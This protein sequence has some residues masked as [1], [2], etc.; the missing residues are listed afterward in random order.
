MNQHPETPNIEIEINRQLKQL[1]SADMVADAIL[2]T[3]EDKKL[4]A[5]DSESLAVYLLN[6]GLYLTLLSFFVR[7]AADGSQ[8]PWAQMGEALA[9]L[10]NDNEEL[11]KLLIEG[12]GAN[13]ALRQLSRCR[14]LD[15]VD[16]ELIEVRRKS[17]GYFLEIYEKRR[18]E[19]FNQLEL[20]KS[21]ELLEEEDKLLQIMDRHFP[22]DPSIR[23]AKIALQEKKALS[24][25]SGRPKQKA[26][27]P[28][29]NFHESL[30]E[31]EEKI[32]KVVQEQ[33][34]TILHQDP[35]LLSDF[36]YFNFFI[37]A[38]DHAV[39]L[40]AEFD[41][42]KSHPWLWAETLIRGRYF[43]EILDL[44]VSL[45]ET[46]LDDPE[47]VFAIHYLRAQALWGLNQKLQAIELMEGLVAIRPTY[48]AAQAILD[49]W[50]DEAQ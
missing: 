45:E 50:R 10:A 15:N 43:V 34:R 12:A 33:M 44:L 49:D 20:L 32:L 13:M 6:S 16:P 7:K 46:F 47:Q 19:F 23:D 29:R 1:E 48:R 21:Q 14:R 8:L 28:P 18:K 26:P 30:T 40:L 38:Y 4:S 36:V 9:M 11:K 3:C 35:Q 39:S 37:D 17:K 2:K 24:F 31:E 22:N 41:S 25:I 5:E 42:K 27:R